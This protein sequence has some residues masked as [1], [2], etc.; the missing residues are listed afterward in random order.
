[1]NRIFL[2]VFLLIIRSITSFSQY[3]LKE[4][5]VEIDE[6]GY[7]TNCIKSFSS[8]EKDIEIPAVIGGKTIKGISVTYDTK[9]A[10]AS[11]GIKSVILPPTIE[12]IG[13]EAFDLNNISKLIIPTNVLEI[14]GRAFSYNQIDSLVLSSNVNRIGGYAFQ[15]NK[16]TFLNIPNGIKEI[17]WNAFQFNEISSVNIPQSIIL[18]EWAAFN[19]NKIDLVNGFQSNGLIYSRTSEGKIDSSKI[20]SYGGV[21]DTIDFIPKYVKTIGKSCFDNNGI[22]RIEL[23]NNIKTIEQ[24]AFA[25]NN[26]SEVIIPYNVVSIGKQAFDQNKIDSVFIPNTVSYIGD[27]AFSNNHKLSSIKLPSP[28]IC[29]DS[30][31]IQWTNGKGNLVN[32]ITDFYTYYIAQFRDTLSYTISGKI[33]IPNPEN[34]MIELSGD[35]YGLREINSDSTFSFRLNSGRHITI[36]PTLR[37]YSFLPTDTV[38]TD[39]NSDILDLF[40]EA[41]ALDSFKITVNKEGEGTIFPEPGEYYYY[42]NEQ[43]SAQASSTNK[44]SFEHWTVGGEIYSDSIISFNVLSDMLLT[45]H[46]TVSSTSIENVSELSSVC[47]PNPF[48]EK[49]NIYTCSSNQIKWIIIYDL[50]GSQVKRINVDLLSNY[51]L[52]LS[53]LE[54]NYFILEI[55]NSKGEKQTNRIIKL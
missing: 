3:I 5:D 21:S 24:D 13:W 47:Y 20:V 30:I 8:N 35:F 33:F 14:G 36:T 54:G 34:V 38:L 50:L 37:G 42:E 45:A 25:R 48:R 1:M 44:W 12:I 26:I 23:P 32:E 29:E 4:T 53:N 18:I 7:I 9:G 55:I 40:F 27:W 22:E 49:I 17:G 39:I 31:F 52:D 16:L 46:F 51:T 19:S 6:N 2:I 41:T 28:V 11:K 10:F 43:F 15:G